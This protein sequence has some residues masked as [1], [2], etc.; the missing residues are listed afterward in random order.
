VRVELDR[1]RGE[2]RVLIERGDDLHYLYLLVDEG[3]VF[4][5]WTT[6]DFRPER[7]KTSERI[8]AY[9][10]LRV[11]AL[12][13]H[14]F[15]GSLRVRGVVVESLQDL[16]GVVGKYHTIDV[17]PGAEVVI[18]KPN[19][20]PLD[21]VVEIERMALRSSVKLLL[22]SIDDEEVAVALATQLGVDLRAVLERRGSRGEVESKE[23]VLEEFYR[24]ANKVVSEVAKIEKPDR[25]ILAGPPLYID[26]YKRITGYR[27]DSEALS[28]G[29]V[30]GVYEFQRLDLIS[31]YGL[32]HGL[33][34][35]ER[36]MRE[37]SSNPD[38]VAIGIERLEQLLEANAVET[39]VITDETFKELALEF[40]RLIS[41]ALRAGVKLVVVP[42]SSEPGEK[43]KSM[44][45]VAALLRYPVPT[46]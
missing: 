17:I 37:L 4:C 6:R 14:K 32:E 44:G 1:R 10:C 20:Y 21:V 31:K 9:L 35:V 40:K 33:K 2:V 28:I 24:E 39:V 22:V 11:E 34:H 5:G 8:K 26:L 41:L 45:G 13:Y 42:E 3:D 16:E 19:G 15:R 7:S 43:L 29:G 25:I 18:R 12:E 27:G 46:L 23:E 38:K 36:I 30:A